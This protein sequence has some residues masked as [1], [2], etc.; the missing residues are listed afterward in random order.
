MKK[1][2]K[3]ISAALLAVLLLAAAVLPVS[4]K[5]LFV[6]QEVAT[7]V[8]NSPKA[9]E[10]RNP[11]NAPGAIVYKGQT[12][13]YTKVVQLPDY[14]PSYGYGGWSWYRPTAGDILRGGCYLG[15]DEG[16]T[17][18]SQYLADNCYNITM[19]VGD[20][21]SF[22]DGAYYYSTDPSV[23][24]YDY[25]A[26]KLVAKSI[27]LAQVYV[28]TRG[29]VPMIRLDVGVRAEF[30]GEKNADTLILTPGT[31]N[32]SSYGSTSLTVTSKSGKL[33][34][35]IAFSVI[36]G[37]NVAYVAD[38]KINTYG[39]GPVVIRAY[40]KSNQN[41][42]G[43]TFLYAG[44]YT[45]SVYDGCW[46]SCKDGIRVSGW[47]YDVYD[48]CGLNG[49]YVSGWIRTDGIYIPVVK[50]YDATPAPTAVPAATGSKI[51]VGDSLTYL[52]LLRMAYGEKDSVTTVLGLY[53]LNRYGTTG[54]IYNAYDYR[55]VL[56]A[57]I[58][59]LLK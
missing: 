32:P 45:S 13:T 30:P 27:G 12:E 15:A 7:L 55:T 23:C 21:R 14:C 52:D 6:S 42:W 24:Y 41:V 36:R 34:N 46:S 18:V 56:L 50:V 16:R 57:S 2:L 22:C 11:V 10:P 25:A 51:L 31:W 3:V 9:L 43:E 38:G 8:P 49:S 39:S 40:S 44:S 33:Y 28:Y 1:S 54:I 47:G 37:Y 19:L 53:N 59:G 20:K 58:L 48:V 26:G 5:T 35:D 4:A 17:A 29:G